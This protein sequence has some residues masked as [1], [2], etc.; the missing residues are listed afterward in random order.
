[1]DVNRKKICNLKIGI[2]PTDDRQN[3]ELKTKTSLRQTGNSCGKF[4]RKGKI[5]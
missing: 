3:G 2:M 5:L 4:N 1:M